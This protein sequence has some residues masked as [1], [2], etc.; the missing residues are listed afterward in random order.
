MSANL[1]LA[2]SAWG[3]DKPV[4]VRALADACDAEN[5]TLVARRLNRSSGLVSSVLSGKY[6]GSMD[7]VEQ[8]VRG[9]LMAETVD[10]PVV[11]ALSTDTCLEHQQAKWAPHNPQ[12]IAFF[13]AC[14]NGC[15]HSRIGGKNHAQ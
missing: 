6:K 14:R 12:R 1:N 4:W 11:G 10:C 15:P 7:A 9:A 13:R 8:V 5:Q 3:D 2:I